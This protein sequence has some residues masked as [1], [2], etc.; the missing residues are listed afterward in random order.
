MATEQV[1]Q[2]FGGGFQSDEDESLK[3]KFGGV[4]GLNAG[5]IITKFELNPNA[6]KDGA[7]SNALDISIKIGDKEFRSRFYEPTKVYDKDSNEI[8]DKTN[9]AFIKGMNEQIKQLKGVITH[10]LKTFKTEEEVK[11]LYAGAT[12][13]SFADLVNF[14]ASVIAPFIVE[15][16]PVDVFLQYQWNIGTDQKMTFLEMPKNLKDGAFITA[17]IEPTGEWKEIRDKDGL[18]YQDNAGNLHRFNRDKNYL[19]SNKAIQQF[20]GGQRGG[21]AGG[22]A[23]APQNQTATGSSSAW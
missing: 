15:E 9:P 13:N 4:F 21:N 11:A 22:D 2:G 14:S 23:I 7:E 10:Y 16:K 1:L 17:S 3:S 5:A 18:R 12:I 19:E 8:T 6:G 20:E